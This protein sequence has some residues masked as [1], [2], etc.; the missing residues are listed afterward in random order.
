MADGWVADGGMGDGGRLL[1]RPLVT[2]ACLCDP[3]TSYTAPL[4]AHESL[5]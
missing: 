2:L 1:R 4:L 5:G 3:V